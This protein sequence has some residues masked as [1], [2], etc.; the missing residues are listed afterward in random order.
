MNAD[1][2]G[3]TRLTN[4]PSMDLFPDWSPDDSRIAFN[5][6]RDGNGMIYVMNADGTGQ[7]R[8]TTDGGNSPSWTP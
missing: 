3:Q 4:S 2:T 7:T 1:G 5:S 8:L 6:Y